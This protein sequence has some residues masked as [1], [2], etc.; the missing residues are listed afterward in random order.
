MKNI[1][2]GIIGAGY[3]G[4]THSLHHSQLK[5][6]RLMA[7]ADVNLEAAQEL[8][9]QY[10]IPQV[11]RNYQELLA[12]PDVDAVSICTPD[13]VHRGPGVMAAE[14]GKHILLEKPIATTIEDAKAILEAVEKAGVVLTIGFVS[15][16]LKTY[17][18]AHKSLEEG[19]IGEVMTI[20]AKRIIRA[21]VG[22]H[23]SKRDTIIDFL[24]IHDIDLLR[25]FGGDIISVFAQA[26]AFVFPSE[27]KHDTAM[28]I[29]RFSNGGMGYFH[30]CWTLPSGVPYRATSTFEVIGKKGV[31]SIDAF[32]Q[33]V[34]I[35]S[36]RGYEIPI[37]W[38]L[39]QAF[40]EQTQRFVNCVRTGQKPLITGEDGLKA[41]EVAIAARKSAREHRPVEIRDI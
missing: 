38:D 5:G 28:A 7:V 31:A 18:L 21:S 20:S 29:V 10:E 2:I 13:A 1:G 14:A 24:A 17:S 40:R 9:T 35:A 11:Y 34:R 6:V 39:T 19:D 30:T 16:F 37:G 15:R 36:S 32:D 8:A 33:S 22:E 3:M 27:D 26:D 23:Y 4:K 12:S 25:W 41:L